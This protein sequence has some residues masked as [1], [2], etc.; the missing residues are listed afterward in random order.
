M[1]AL[2][3][4]V[5]LNEYAHLTLKPISNKA[6]KKRLRLFETKFLEEEEEEFSII[7]MLECE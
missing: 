1:F 2:I 3:A 4:F 7:E 5:A 6:V